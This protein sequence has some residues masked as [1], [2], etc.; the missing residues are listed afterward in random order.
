LSQEN[1]EN[2]VLWPSPP[3]N[4]NKAGLTKLVVKD[5]ETI[6]IIERLILGGGQILHRRGSSEFII[7]KDTMSDKTILHLHAVD[8][9]DGGPQPRTN[10][11]PSD[12]ETVKLYEIIKAKGQLEPIHVY[13]SPLGNGKYR[14]WEGHRRHMIIFNMLML[15]EILAI[16]ENYTEQQ[17]YDAVLSLHNTRQNFSFYDQGHY[18]TEVLVKRFPDIYRTQ[19]DIGEHLR[20]SHDSISVILKAYREAEVQKHNLS[21]ENSRRLETLSKDII[22]QVSKASEELKPTLYETIIEKNLSVRQT[23]ELVKEV[24]ADPNADAAKI[25][26]E[27]QKIADEKA[28]RYM[29]EADKEKAK[30]ARA[31]DKVVAAGE[32]CPVPEALMTAVFGH[33]GLKNKGKVDPEKAKAYAS[34]LVAV[35][36]RRALEKDELDTALSEADTWP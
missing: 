2:T 33:L 21:P 18:I 22:V 30:T 23:K 25:A 29:K 34:K 28:V 19:E 32:T 6:P 16:N 27:A 14:I 15:P 31:R 20:L 13:P 3:S 24:N 1:K 8:I 11:D 4:K 9:E 17:A 10:I 35:F 7:S 26:E 12:P 5:K 36:F